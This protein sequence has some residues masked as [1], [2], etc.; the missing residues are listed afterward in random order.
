MFTGIIQ[1]MGRVVQREGLRLEI[2]GPLA[3]AGVGDSIAVN[4]VCLTVIKARGSVKKRRV[5][6]DLS[7][8]TVQR[9]TIG[10]WGVGRW[11]N[12][13]PA[14][15]AGDSMGGHT[16]QGHVDGV[17]RVI[18][19]EPK[20]DWSLYTFSIPVGMRDYFVTKGSVA[21]DGIS[22]T[23]LNPRQNRFQVAI[24]PHTEK[25]TVLGNYRAGDEVNIEADILAKQVTHL[26]KSWRRG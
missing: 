22:L 8:E 17:G 7:E 1:G 4:G 5:L 16:V 14:L 10:S 19:R 23:I 9:T 11:V 26:M 3:R 21:V 6:F 18:R 12:L 24:I 25:V 15:R 2:E 13:E 20:G